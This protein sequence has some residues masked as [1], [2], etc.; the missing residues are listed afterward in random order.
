MSGRYLRL[1][2]LRIS[3]EESLRDFVFKGF[4]NENEFD[5]GKICLDEV[6]KGMVYVLF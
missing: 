6:K 2:V 3:I 5:E 1:V 4:E